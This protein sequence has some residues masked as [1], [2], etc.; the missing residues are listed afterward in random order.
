MKICRKQS[1][2]IPAIQLYVTGA[3]RVQ[4]AALMGLTN[5]FKPAAKGGGGDPWGGG[6]ITQINERVGHY[7]GRIRKLC[8]L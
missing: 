1:I 4:I 5:P 7:V 8:R 6:Y 2:R 3:G